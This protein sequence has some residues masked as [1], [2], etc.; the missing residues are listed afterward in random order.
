MKQRQQIEQKDVTALEADLFEDSKEQESPLVGSG[1]RGG[2][3]ILEEP[4]ERLIAPDE[5][6]TVMLSKRAFSQVEH[7]DNGQSRFPRESGFKRQKRL[8]S[9][10]SC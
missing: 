7:S 4:L 2:G 1:H 5:S 8:E 9:R 10:E 6:V 3:R